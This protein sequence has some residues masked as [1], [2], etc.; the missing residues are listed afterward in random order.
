[1]YQQPSEPMFDIKTVSVIGRYT[2][3]KEHLGSCIGA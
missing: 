1:M 3:P 2:G